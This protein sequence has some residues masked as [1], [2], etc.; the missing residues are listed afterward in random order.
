MAVRR[1]SR[2]SPARCGRAA[3][4]RRERAG[5]PWSRA[6]RTPPRRRRASPRSS[7]GA[8]VLGLHL[9]Y[10]LRP[11]SDADEE[12][13]RELCGRL[14]LELVVERPGPRR[15]ETCRPQAREAR[16][17]AAERLRLER[18]LDWI[19]TGHTRTDL[20]ET[21]LYRLA[22]SPG[23]AGAAR[24][25]PRGGAPWCA[26][27]STLTATGA[28]ARRAGADFPSATTRPTPS[29]SMR[30]TGSAPRSCRCCARSGRPRRRAIAETQ[31]ELAEE[32]RRWSGSPPRR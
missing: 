20:A 11:D 4:S 24:A 28:A 10:G 31:A 18:G 32:A 23:P 2:L 30:G 16:Y 26:R 15:R 9:D 17:A 29:P 27:C 25:S 14:G 13:C 7:A 19:A 3:S 12:A 5:S 6:A 21:V 8:A 22:T 1:R